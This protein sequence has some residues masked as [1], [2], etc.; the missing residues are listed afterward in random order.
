MAIRSYQV[1][2]L[3]ARAMPSQQFPRHVARLLLTLAHRVAS[4]PIEPYTTLNG[5]VQPA[6]RAYGANLPANASVLHLYL[7]VGQSNMVGRGNGD[8]LSRELAGKL[9]AVGGLANPDAPVAFYAAG[10]AGAGSTSYASTGCTLGFE[11]SEPVLDV[12]SSA[13]QPIER[14]PLAPVESCGWEKSA[15]QLNS[16]F[17]PELSLGLALHGQ[18]PE[19]QFVLLKR[20]NSGSTLAGDWV[21]GS[22]GYRALLEDVE[23]IR[24]ANPDKRVVPTGL[25]WLQGEA[26]AKDS[27]KS[28]SYGTNIN[29]LITQLR[30][31]IDA[32]A[33]AVVLVG[34]P[35]AGRKYQERVNSAL[36]KTRQ[37]L[38]GVSFVY[39]ER[40]HE[41][42]GNPRRHLPIGSEGGVRR[43][44]QSEF[45]QAL[46]QLVLV[47]D[48]GCS[49][50]TDAGKTLHLLRDQVCLHYTGTAQLRIG[51]RA[52]ELFA[53]MAGAQP[54]AWPNGWDMGVARD[55]SRTLYHWFWEQED[56][57]LAGRPNASQIDA[58]HDCFGVGD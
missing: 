12:S 55:D 28:E 37:S 5:P 24:K 57:L 58:D 31:D 6:G 21:P 41:P 34:L 19:R 39:N 47:G 30:K 22:H 38:P 1:C 10:M 53:T 36:I 43:A 33:L 2:R 46:G 16:H 40:V 9:N 49:I 26:D 20:A 56:Q 7:L 51:A 18:W 54:A 35:G 44:S 27:E 15:M 29:R 42:E 17:G 3:A 13:F 45:E 11:H 48:V 14:L 8:D 32:P 4:T 23:V 25:L 50:W 52:A